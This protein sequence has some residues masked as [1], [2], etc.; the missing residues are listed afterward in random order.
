MIIKWNILYFLN[1]L[2]TQIE[3]KKYSAYE[4]R[5]SRSLPLCSSPFVSTLCLCTCL[6]P[7]SLLYLYPLILL[8]ASPPLS[9]LLPLPLCLF[10]YFYSLSFLCMYL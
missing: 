8:P 4:C 1:K 7:L 6:Y 9:L 3:N 10:L 5:E 2:F